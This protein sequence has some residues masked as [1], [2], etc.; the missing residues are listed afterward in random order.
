MARRINLIPLQDRTRTNTDLALLALVAAALL[1][2]FGLGFG[3]YLLSNTL[4]DRERELAEI[5]Q[6]ASLLEAQVAQL[7]QYEALQTQRIR[8]EGVVQGI[9][10]S[11]TLV[12][13]ILDSVSLVVPE[14]VWFQN[15]T[16]ATSDPAAGSADATPLADNELSIDGS[17]YSFE[18]VAQV[19]VRLQLVPSLEDVELVS[20]GQASQSSDPTQDIK[21]F[22]I[23][24]AVINT[25]PEDTP[26]PLSQVEVDQ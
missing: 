1:I 18:D 5:E 9:Y 22:S 23:E 16:L 15:L 7:N 13:D 2:V 3:Y 12:S 17:T 4:G 26:L 11:R 6:Q 8:A 24:A 25:Q 21:G 10:A 20:A 14:A 19:L